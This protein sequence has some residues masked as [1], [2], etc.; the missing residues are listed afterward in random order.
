MYIEV[1]PRGFPSTL[2]FFTKAAPVDAG[3]PSHGGNA[4]D[5]GLTFTKR[6]WGD[7]EDLSRCEVHFPS[8]ARS[9]SLISLGVQVCFISNFT[10]LSKFA[11]NDERVMR[12][13]F[14]WRRHFQCST[15]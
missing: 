3:G 12:F 4:R 13:C 15:V 7:A 2:G 8:A 9:Q 6:S 5:V 11:A 14:L 1:V 10:S